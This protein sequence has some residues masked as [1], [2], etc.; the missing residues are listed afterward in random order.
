MLLEEHEYDE[1]QIR[2]VS[3]R[4]GVALA[5]LYRYFTS[6]EH[7][8]VAV[9]IEWSKTY[10]LRQGA[11]GKRLR[12]DADRLRYLLVRAV[13]AF[14]RRPQLFRAEMVLESSQDPT[15]APSTTSSPG[16][17]SAC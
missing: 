7:L 1:I 11:D 16:A 10:D 5:T 13:R 4:A 8:Y 14:G 12:T 15:R 9:L 17:T 2:D 6:K 3:E